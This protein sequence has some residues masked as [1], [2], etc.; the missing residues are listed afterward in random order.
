MLDSILAIPVVQEQVCFKSTALSSLKGWLI[1]ELCQLS[2]SLTCCNG[3]LPQRRIPCHT[4]LMAPWL[5]TQ[6][7]PLLVLLLPLLLLPRF[8][9]LI[10]MLR[11]LWLRLL[12]KLLQ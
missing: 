4:V 12:V 3:M 7:L 2:S 11:L 9:L 1:S 6:L 5:L 10:V 8:L